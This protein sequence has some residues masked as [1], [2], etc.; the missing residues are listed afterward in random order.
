MEVYNGGGISS[1]SWNQANLTNYESYP[2]PNSEECLEFNDCLW[3][4]QFAF[5]SGVQPESWVAAHNI[6][7]VHEKDADQYALK[8]LR[9]R[10]GG[11]EID[12]T[13]YDMCA[14]SDCSGYCTQNANQNGP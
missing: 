7:A 11:N 4:G 9:L 10:Q 8:A 14:D 6:A 13:V 1:G 5:L 2:D 12:V 3:A